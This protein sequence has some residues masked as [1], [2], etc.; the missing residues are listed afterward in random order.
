MEF[1]KR[2]EKR[3]REAERSKEI[4]RSV[5]FLEFNTRSKADRE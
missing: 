4:L 5:L 1:R 2:E 3:G